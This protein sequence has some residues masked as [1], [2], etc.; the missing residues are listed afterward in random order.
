[1]PLPQGPVL[2]VAALRVAELARARHN[3]RRLLAR[4]GRE[5]GAGHYPLVVALHVAWLVALFPAIPPDRPPVWAALAGFTM[6]QAAQLWI[7]VSLGEYWTTRVITVP[8]AALI[9]R[10]PYRWLRH[11]NYLVVAAEI[12]LLPMVFGA[13]PIALT[14]SLANALVLARRIRVEDAALAQRRPL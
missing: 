11:P 9:R 13:W 3:Q 7:I 2:A 1:M 4:G 5:L 12:A 10:G 6:L 8:G 14:F